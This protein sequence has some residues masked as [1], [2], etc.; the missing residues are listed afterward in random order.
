MTLVLPINQVQRRDAKY[1]LHGRQTN[2]RHS[3][4]WHTF[5]GGAG[6]RSWY[7]SPI[8]W[9]IFKNVMTALC[10]CSSKHLVS[11]LYYQKSI[12]FI[13][14]YSSISSFMIYGLKCGC[15]FF[16]FW[17]NN[18]FFLDN[19]HKAIII[20]RAKYLFATVKERQSATFRVI[21]F[22]LWNQPFYPMLTSFNQ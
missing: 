11:F 22:L 16:Y 12:L 15:W 17:I 19:L 14:V 18:V 10:D 6:E 8:K 21:G 4:G 5:G 3:W 2:P 9:F 7:H 1:G 20:F 13:Y